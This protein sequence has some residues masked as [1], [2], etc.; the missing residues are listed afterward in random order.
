MIRVERGREG[1]TVEEE[2]LSDEGRD[3]GLAGAAVERCRCRRTRV[4]VGD[5]LEG[6]VTKGEEVGRTNGVEQDS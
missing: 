2:F 4:D 6:V 5:S 1:C 3:P